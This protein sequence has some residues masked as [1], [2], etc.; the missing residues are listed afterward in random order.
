MNV[1]GALAQTRPTASGSIGDKRG[2][3]PVL[4]WRR[5]AGASQSLS[6]HPAR[7]PLRGKA[8]FVR[9]SSGR[10]S[11]LLRRDG[12]GRP[13]GRGEQVGGSTGKV[14]GLACKQPARGRQLSAS[15]F[16]P[17]I[18][19]WRYPSPTLRPPCTVASAEYRQVLP[20]QQ[21]ATGAAYDGASPPLAGLASPAGCRT[22]HCR[23]HTPSLSHRFRLPQVLPWSAG[24]PP[25]KGQAQAV[26][27]L[28]AAVTRALW[29]FCRSPSRCL[30]PTPQIKVGM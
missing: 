28:F 7:R 19:S 23:R 21:I 3:A 25:R 16:K 10:S 18:P 26:L 29:H 15:Q 24:S 30:C 2:G 5:P 14:H 4:E 8:S 17:T 11:G 12:R 6:V 22:P 1:L 13:S 9:R 27:L 20:L